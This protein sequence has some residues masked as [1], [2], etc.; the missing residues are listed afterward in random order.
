MRGIVVA[1][2]VATAGGLSALPA[3]ADVIFD[4]LGPKNLYDPNVG[5]SVANAGPF[6]VNLDQAAAFTP[7]GSY[8]LDSIEIAIGHLGGPNVLFVDVYDDAD[9]APGSPLASVTLEEEMGPFGGDL[10]P[11]VVAAF[12]GDLVLHAGQQYWLVLSG[13]DTTDSWLAWNYNVQGDV[14]LRAWREDLGPWNLDE[15]DPNN[16]RG[17]FR[18]NGTLVP[19]PGAI[20]PWLGAWA[21]GRRRR[22]G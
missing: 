9:G 7:G 15:G 6:G 3:A 20:A 22:R 18:V 2:C 21:I 19:G 17:A 12:A 5:W 1:A 16:P 10:E 13:D 8:F 11:P 14:G 4:N